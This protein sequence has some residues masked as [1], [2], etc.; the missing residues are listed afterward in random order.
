MLNK[1]VNIM[2]K[3]KKVDRAWTPKIIEQMNDYQIKVAK[4]KGEFTWHDHVE[5][6][7]VFIVIEGEMTIQFEDK[8]VNL[9]TG[10]LYV[11]PKGVVHKPTA[12]KECHVLLIEPKGTVNT[13]GVENQQTASN[14]E[15][16]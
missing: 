13:G 2:S 8:T 12:L 15:W 14:K 5:T 6:D 16:V 9:K 1:V 11:V 3:L 7:E 10:D 4:F